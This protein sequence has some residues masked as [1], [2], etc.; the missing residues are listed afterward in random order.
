MNRVQPLRV[1]AA[2]AATGS[3]RAPARR[4]A[5]CPANSSAAIVGS[6]RKNDGGRSWTMSR[7]AAA[8][9]WKLSSS[10]SA[11]GDAARR[12]GRRRPARGRSAR[13]A[14]VF[15]SSR[16]RC[17]RPLACGRRATVKSAAS[18]RA[19]SSSSSMP[20]SST[21]RPVAT[22]VASSLMATLL[23][24]QPGFLAPISAIVACL[25]LASSPTILE[26]ARG[27]RLLLARSQAADEVPRPF[28]KRAATQHQGSEK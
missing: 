2:R 4:C 13:S 18:R 15:S 3:A 16:R 24:R 9:M 19:C 14:R 17:A 12:G 5:A 28:V 22:S 21:L 10:H 26:F 1:E 7:P 23:I 8:T 25:S 11:A 6:R 20:S 27:E